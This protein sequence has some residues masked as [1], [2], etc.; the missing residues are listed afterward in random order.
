MKK[1]KILVLTDHSKHSKENSLYAMIP[2]MLKHPEVEQIDIA[3]RGEELNRFFFQS[4]IPKSLFVTKANENFAFSPNGSIFKKGLRR[5]F[6]KE[7]DMV[8]LRLPPP[9][10]PDFLFFLKTIFAKKLIINDPFGIYE[11]GS[12]EFLM[13]FEEFCPPMKICKSVEDIVDFKTRFPIVLKPFREYGGRG[14]VRIDG[15]RVW[16]GSQET[17][18][19]SFIEK[20]DGEPVEY[21]GVKFLK[22]VSKGDKRIVVANGEIIGCSLRLPA[23]N[24]WLCNIA[25]GGRSVM[26]EV[27]DRE[28]EIVKAVNPLVM[29]LGIVMYGVDTLVG[30]DGQ[31]ILSELNT[32]S[33]GGV[34]QMARQTGLP[35]TEKTVNQIIQ[36]SIEKINDKQAIA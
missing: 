4:L 22:N 1:L 13:N 31:R 9:L 11:T 24:S 21:L 2:A 5:E 34:P 33:I 14:L 25:Q 18:F 32:T 29:N 20:M 28:R 16:E 15:H 6:L 3:T 8:W 23:E 19:L 30:D 17:D 12:K 35:L 36:F 27:D 7:Y 10:A 26:A